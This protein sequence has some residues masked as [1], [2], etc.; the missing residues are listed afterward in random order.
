MDTGVS[1]RQTKWAIIQEPPL[2]ELQEARLTTI[3]INENDAPLRSSGL[4]RQITTSTARTLV[5]NHGTPL[6]LFLAH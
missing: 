3:H 6:T 5:R 4:T 1:T 2:N